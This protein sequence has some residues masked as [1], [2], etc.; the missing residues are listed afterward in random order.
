MSNHYYHC[1]KRVVNFHP[2]F[3]RNPT[4]G[5]RAGRFTGYTLTTVGLALGGALVY[6][7]Y[8][9]VFKNQANKIVP[10]FAQLVDTV[11]DLFV[12]R[13]SS[14]RSRGGTASDSS[15]AGGVRVIGSEVKRGSVDESAV[16]SPTGHDTQPISQT[17]AEDNET[18]DIQPQ[19]A[20]K[21]L[22]LHF[23]YINGV[24][25]LLRFSAVGNLSA[26]S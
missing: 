23:L 17:K 15:A 5:F 25:F 1:N 10:G 19:V 3:P 16:K 14:G 12:D 4:G 8:D 18:R 24:L 2:I 13:V 6:A 7:N 22:C 26:H 11:A 21:S 20:L 9:P